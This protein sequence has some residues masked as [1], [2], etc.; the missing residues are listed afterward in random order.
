[1]P[2]RC[3]L[4]EGSLALTFR[5]IKRRLFSNLKITGLKYIAM[6][7]GGGEFGYGDPDLDNR[8][9]HDDD[10]YEEQEVERTQPFQPGAAST[11]YQPG[12][13]YHVGEQTEMRA[14]QHEQSG[15]PDTSYAETSFLGE[16]TPLIETDSERKSVLGRLKAA[17]PTF[18]TEKCAVMKGTTGKNKGKIVAIGKQGGEYKIMKDD[19]TDFTKKFL[20]SFKKDLGPSAADI[21]AEDRDT[22][23]EQRQRL[24][25]A[26]IQLQQAE[27]LSSQREE[28]K[29]EVEALRRKIEQTDAQIDAIQDEQGSNLESEAEL[30]RLKELKNNHQSDL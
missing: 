3:T 9:D 25:E 2:F 28:E 14:M 7:E 12:T 18:S 10:D 26:E 19:W 24:T 21:I 27:T 29:K 5:I 11:P 1:M 20:D 16:D 22:I 8:V 17:F 15:L 30:R 23:R 4:G 6:A 13:P